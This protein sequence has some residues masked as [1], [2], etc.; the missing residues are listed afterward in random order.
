MDVQQIPSNGEIAQYAGYGLTDI[1]RTTVPSDGED[2][3]APGCIC[4]HV[5]GNTAPTVLYV[6]TGTFDSAA[7]VGILPLSSSGAI[8][9]TD[10]TLDS[11][12]EIN[13]TF[14]GA[15]A[16]AIDDAAIVGNTSAGGTA[17]K[18]VF[19]ETQ[20]G[21]DWSFGS[22]AGNFTFTAGIGGAA[23]SAD[24][25]G[26]DSGCISFVTQTGGSKDGTGTAGANG[27][28]RLNSAGNVFFRQGA[29]ATCNATGTLPA[30]SMLNGMV[31]STTAAAV[32][33]TVD[34]GTLM[35]AA[36]HAEV[37]ADEGFFWTVINTGPNTFTLQAATGHTLVGSAAVATS[38]S[39][40]FFTRRTG[41]NTFVTYRV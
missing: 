14:G 40:T 8:S 18:S 17:G 22:A 38:T 37:G 7:F 19:I 12:N 36:I 28:I 1:A 9:I 2:G 20:D 23:L 35:D 6:N 3:Y 25:N 27:V 21:S 41:S 34:T 30:A 29:P 10:L 32:T 5:D 39:A 11:T 26:G 33:A 15:G 4:R 24:Q 31:T 13:I 16:L